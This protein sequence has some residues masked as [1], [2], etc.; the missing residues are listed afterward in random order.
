MKNESVV[1][2]QQAILRVN[3]QR[4]AQSLVSIRGSKATIN[5]CRFYIIW[6]LNFDLSQ[7]MQPRTVR[8]YPVKKMRKL[9]RTENS[10]FFEKVR[11]YGEIFKCVRVFFHSRNRISP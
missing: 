4:T 1:H 10:E 7:K 11:M 3:K 9:L 6:F 2:V 8:H 5:N